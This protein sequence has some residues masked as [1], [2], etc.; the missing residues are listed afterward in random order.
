MADNTKHRRKSIGTLKEDIAQAKKYLINAKYNQARDILMKIIL[1]R[2]FNN[3]SP[4]IFYLLGVSCFGSNDLTAAKT[5][6]QT[7]LEKDNHHILSQLYLVVI[8][9]LMDNRLQAAEYL[10]SAQEEA[11]RPLNKKYKRYIKQTMSYLKKYGEDEEKLSLIFN[12]P[13]KYHILPIYGEDVRH[14]RIARNIFFVIGIVGV[15][16]L[17]LWYIYI[18]I[19]QSANIKNNERM[20]IINQLNNTQLAGDSNV[21]ERQ[22]AV[23]LT[24]KELDNLMSKIEKSF[25]NYDDNQVW[26]NANTI[27]HS[28]VSQEEKNKVLLITKNLSEINYASITTWYDYKTVQLEPWKYNNVVVKWKG[29]IVKKT[30]ETN[31]D[32]EPLSV[33]SLHQFL[34]DYY[35]NNKELSAT[36]DVILPD[37]IQLQSGNEVELLSKLVIDDSNTIVLE[38]IS[39][40]GL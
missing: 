3:N 40:S 19:F 12:N 33:G 34:V 8:F 21:G 14:K 24:E 17:G 23:V 31:T 20:R 2:E 30:S 10:L 13:M 32:T 4:L 25:I 6:F 39:F 11:E 29:T 7:A 36:L 35:G 22:T 27:L 28:N 38:V 5:Y 1:H 15:L 16:G 37:S 26:V 9:M 18:N